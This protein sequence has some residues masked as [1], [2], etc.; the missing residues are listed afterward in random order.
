MNN[1]IIVSAA[2]LILAAIASV[3]IIFAAGNGQDDNS[4]RT[5]TG[6]IKAVEA[7][8]TDQELTEASMHFIE[9]R[10]MIESEYYDIQT[11]QFSEETLLLSTDELVD[12]MTGTFHF[13]IHL[14][15]DSGMAV[16]S[17]DSLS[18]TY[19]YQHCNIIAEILSRDDAAEALY[20]GY[21]RLLDKPAEEKILPSFT[22]L[23]L[24]NMLAWEPV[25]E[26]LPDAWK[27]EIYDS[28]ESYHGVMNGLVEVN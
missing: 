2:A 12:K 16:I 11:D 14:A 22:D 27:A 10:R 3:L 20:R 28:A 18:R 15:M 24:L 17:N 13:L 7:D 9:E 4:G 23:F 25:Y 19:A 26:Q 6:D 1:K 5:D 8:S 21:F